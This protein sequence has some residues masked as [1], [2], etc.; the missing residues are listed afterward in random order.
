MNIPP[1]K[2]WSDDRFENRVDAFLDFADSNPYLS[3]PILVYCPCK[4]CKKKH[5]C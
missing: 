4:R 2:S 1:I 5:G 3:E